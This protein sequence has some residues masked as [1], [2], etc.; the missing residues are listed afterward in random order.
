M[1][2]KITPLLSLLMVIYLLILA[3]E[4]PMSHPQIAQLI[5]RW[6]ND[7]IFRSALRKNPEEALNRSGVKL[8]DEEWAAFKK[9]D[10]SKSDQELQ[11]L[12]S[13]PLM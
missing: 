12:I 7:S 6:I 3:K 4:A 13:K 1:Q 10:W 9:I 2:G 5:E 8:T 11:T